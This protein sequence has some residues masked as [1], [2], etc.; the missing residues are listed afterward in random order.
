MTTDKTGWRRLDTSLFEVLMSKRD[1]RVLEIIVRSCPQKK[2][3]QTAYYQSRTKPP[4]ELCSADFESVV[5]SC[6]RETFIMTLRASE[7]D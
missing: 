5:S 3:H 7:I 6:S 4:T 1:R 2:L